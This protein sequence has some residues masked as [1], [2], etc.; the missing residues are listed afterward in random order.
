MEIHIKGNPSEGNYTLE[1]VHTTDKGKIAVLTSE[2]NIPF[3]GY[4]VDTK[5]KEK[6]IITRNTEWIFDGKHR[7]CSKCGTC[8]C[9]ED[10]DGEFIPNRFCPNCGTR[11]GKHKRLRIQG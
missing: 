3:I 1:Y 2:D 8:F 5:E 9:S 4:I 6:P 10:K 11:M 7:I